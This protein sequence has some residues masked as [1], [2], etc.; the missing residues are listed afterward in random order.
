MKLTTDNNKTHET[1][2]M[3]C[4]KNKKD[5]SSNWNSCWKKGNTKVCQKK[6]YL[7]LARIRSKNSSDTFVCH[8]GNVCY[9][10]YILSKTKSQHEDENVE[11]KPKKILLFPEMRL[12]KKIFTRTAPKKLFLSV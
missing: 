2:L 6:Y 5:D 4:Q 9:K 1:L 8:S 7:V 12:T 11:D 10:P 3:I